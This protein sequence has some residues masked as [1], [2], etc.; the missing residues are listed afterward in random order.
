MNA[1]HKAK[2]IEV[3]HRRTM[4]GVSL[5]VYGDRMIVDERLAQRW[6]NEY[7]LWLNGERPSNLH[8]IK[9]C[10]PYFT[11]YN[12]ITILWIFKLRYKRK[13]FES[14]SRS[15]TKPISTSRL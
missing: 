3:M 10:I 5:Q 11:A 6:L 14:L 13:L 15:I 1:Y 12:T 8:H 4:R 9:R 7:R 2:H